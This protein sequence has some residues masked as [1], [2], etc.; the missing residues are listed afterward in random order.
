MKAGTKLA[1]LESAIRGIG[2][3]AWI[4]DLS[5]FSLS[6]VAVIGRRKSLRNHCTEHHAGTPPVGKNLFHRRFAL[7]NERRCKQ[8]VWAFVES[9]MFSRTSLTVLYALL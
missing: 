2:A 9:P 3:A 6:A 7:R 5:V 1:G 4:S 8:N